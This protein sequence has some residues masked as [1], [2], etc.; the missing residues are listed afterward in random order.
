M[1]DPAPGGEGASWAAALTEAR[2]A[3]AMA[4]RAMKCI[5]VSSL[6]EKSSPIFA[7]RGPADN[8]KAPETSF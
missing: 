1:S 6:E 7:S 3:A 2:P 5:E 8:R 4:T